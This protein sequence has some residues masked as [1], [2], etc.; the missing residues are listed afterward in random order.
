[1][2]GCRSESFISPQCARNTLAF[3]MTLARADAVSLSRSRAALPVND[4]CRVES[5]LRL[6]FSSCA[7]ISCLD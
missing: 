4:Q 5:R 7:V 3:R 1:M 6:S 2:V